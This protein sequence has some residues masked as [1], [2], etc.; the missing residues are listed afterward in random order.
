[1][2]ENDFPKLYEILTN[3]SV[4]FTEALKCQ[5]QFY[6]SLQKSDKNSTVFVKLVKIP[7]CEKHFKDLS[8]DIFY[9]L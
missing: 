4:I 3:F 8:E 9:D 6:F 7:M 5:R 2:I 1:M